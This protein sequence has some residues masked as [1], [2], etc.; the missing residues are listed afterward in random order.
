MLSH[1]FSPRSEGKRNSGGP[2]VGAEKTSTLL[3]PLRT[4]KEPE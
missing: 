3:K 2:L 4:V 1:D